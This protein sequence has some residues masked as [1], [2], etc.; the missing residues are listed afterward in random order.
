MLLTAGGLI[1]VPARGARRGKALDEVG[2]AI[3]RDAVARNV[4]F[5][6]AP[7]LRVRWKAWLGSKF[8]L[9]LD[10]FKSAIAQG[11]CSVVRVTL[12]SLTVL[13]SDRENDLDRLRAFTGNLWF[14]D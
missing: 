8:A 2:A 12:G 6:G 13:L 11:K 1:S 3:P 4:A 7:L 9:V 5:T 14:F 10:L